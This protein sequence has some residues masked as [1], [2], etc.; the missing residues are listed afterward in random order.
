MIA[1]M[2]YRK[3]VD[4]LRALAVLAVVLFHIEPMLLPGGFVGVDIF[5]VISGYLITSIIAAH[6][7]QNGFSFG[8]FFLRRV[9]RIAPAYFVVTLATL[10]VGCLLMLPADLESLG[11]SALWSAFSLPNVFFWLHLDT[12]YFAAD[13]RQLPLLHLWSL[14]AEEQFYLL[15]PALLVLAMRHL[16]YRTTMVLLAL[17]VLASFQFAQV[18]AVS[19]PA[20]AYYMLPTRAGE[21]GMGALLALSRFARTRTVTGGPGYE[22]LALLGMILVLHALF[23]LDRNSLFPGWNAFYPCL[24]TT[25]LILAGSRRECMVTAPLRWPPVVGLGLMSYSIYLWHWPVLAYMRYY[26]PSLSLS[27]ATVALL[28]IFFLAAASYH[29]IEKKWRH[30]VMSRR[31]QVVLLFLVPLILVAG[32]SL[33]VMHRADKISEVLGSRAYVR[34]QESLR[35]LTAPAYEYDYNCQLSEFDAKVMDNPKCVHGDP[36]P[37]L[38][39]VLLWGDSH[40]AHHIGVLAPIAEKH[41]FQLRNASYSTCPP[42]WSTATDYGSGEYREGCTRFR[43]MMETAVAAYPTIVLGA[44]WSV[45]SRH[46]GFESNLH[47]TISTLISHGKRV[48]ILGEVPAFPNYDPAC[49]AR[50]LRR[51]VVDCRTIASRVDDGPAQVNRKL[52]AFAEQTP[53]VYYMD[54]HDL[55]CVGGTCSPYLDGQP[56]YFDSNHLSMEGSWKIGRRLAASSRPLPAALL[57]A[58]MQDGDPAATAGSELRV[59][60]SH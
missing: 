23:V 43:K 46:E 57:P 25:L 60:G 40:A 29:F 30:A 45:H 54:V 9:R 20:F 32:F 44:Q 10:A 7:Q 48:V 50:N 33:L 53:G 47:H 16:Q 11:R 39:K 21:L 31:A 3:D 13:S 19:D 5:F 4:G 38:G 18:K 55:I 24:G 52:R 14:G 36:S 8:W 42:V 2:A 51:Q 26:S 58:A 37:T 49:E 56:I 28:A 12:G 6:I 1:G 22:L 17:L 35:L 41:G 59:P 27:A 15:W 34:A